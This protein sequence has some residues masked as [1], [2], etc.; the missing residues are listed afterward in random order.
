MCI[1]LYVNIKRPT[2]SKIQQNMS[3]LN[4]L[5]VCYHIRVTIFATTTWVIW[6]CATYTVI[7]FSRSVRLAGNQSSSQSVSQPARL[8]I[9]LSARLSVRQCGCLQ[10]VLQKP[11]VTLLV[12]DHS[13]AALPVVPV[14]L[15]SGCGSLA[16][17]TSCDQAVVST[18]HRCCSA[19][20]CRSL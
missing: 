20:C 19:A 1:Q 13:S 10:S 3:N 14:Q 15:Q 12:R 11:Q 2:F 9:S 6:D 5:L 7:A 16:E 4:C 18:L 8:S 17:K